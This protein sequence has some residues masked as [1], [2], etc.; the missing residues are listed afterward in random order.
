M[1][2]HFCWIV[3]Y[4]RVQSQAARVFLLIVYELGLAGAVGLSYGSLHL[5]RCVIR[6]P[7]FA[8][9]ATGER[10]SVPYG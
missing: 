9:F 3:L 4:K 5:R 7:T 6:I 2:L 8:A 10:L 1:F